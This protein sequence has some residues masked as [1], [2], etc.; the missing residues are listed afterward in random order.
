M[1]Q[2]AKPPECREQQVLFPLK[3]DEAVP[4]QHP[5]AADKLDLLPVHTTSLK[6]KA[7]QFDKA[8][9]VYDE[10]QDVY[11]CP[12]GKRLK[13]HHTTPTETRQGTTIRRRYWANSA[14]CAACPLKSRCLQDSARQRSLNRDQYESHR[15]RQA[16]HMAKPES[17]R[18]LTMC[19]AS[20]S[21]ASAASIFERDEKRRDGKFFGH[22][23]FHH[24]PHC[25]RPARVASPRP[26]T[27]KNPLLV[28]GRLTARIFRGK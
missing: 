1:T 22:R 15:E 6:T 10:V 19:S 9:F 3:L 8:A 25:A 2:W 7:K 17:F 26:P 28:G 23:C 21:T 12:N 24:T 27:S 13:Y 5:V 18:L 20:A 14:D 4:T 16:Q 11:W